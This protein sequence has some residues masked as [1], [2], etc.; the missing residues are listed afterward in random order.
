MLTWITNRHKDEYKS[1]DYYTKT[2][3]GRPKAT[4]KYTIEQLERWNMIGVYKIE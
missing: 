2:T 4:K 3:T 1:T